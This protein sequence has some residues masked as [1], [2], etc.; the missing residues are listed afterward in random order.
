MQNDD[1]TFW[2]IFAVMLALGVLG[3]RW[4]EIELYLW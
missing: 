4:M 1:W 2:P 3:L